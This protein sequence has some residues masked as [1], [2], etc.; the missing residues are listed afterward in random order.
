MEKVPTGGLCAVFP[1]WYLADLLTG[2]TAPRRLC[3]IY[4]L[5]PSKLQQ[6]SY[7]KNSPCF[8]GITL[9]SSVWDTG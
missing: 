5:W 6:H 3:L 8:S 9:L 1:Q 7:S 2:I 4:I